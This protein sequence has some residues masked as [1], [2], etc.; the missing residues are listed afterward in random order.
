MRSSP[1]E[2]H[3]ERPLKMSEFTP[4]GR[5]SW[6]KAA[7][8]MGAAVLLGIVVVE[9]LDWWRHVNEPNARV[10]VD[11]TLLSS[12][13]NGT[14]EVVHARRGQRV[15]RGALLA[16]MDT[17]V[18]ELDV[19]T[20]AAEIAK[21]RARRSQIEAE[22]ANYQREMTD[23]IATAQAAVNLLR[24]EHATWKSRHT[25]AQRNVERNKKLAARRTI[26]KRQFDEARDRLL[27]VTSNLRSLE[28]EYQTSQKKLFELRNALKKETVY[29]SRIEAIDRA[30]DKIGVQLRQS[31]QR[32]ADMH[33]HAPIAGVI[34]EVYLSA[35]VYVEDGDRAFLLHDPDALWLEAR[36]DESDISLVAPGQAVSIEFDAYPFEYF[37][38]MVRTIGHATLGSMTSGSKQTADP[39]LAQRIPVLIDLPKMDKPVRPGMRASVNITVR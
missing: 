29:R 2:W 25:I 13:V 12:S 31:K 35:G 16:S 28:T 7:L 20:L 32:L 34:D 11:F 6:L 27:D 8:F 19:A 26:S 22:L 4:R 1:R 9:S 30:I 21:E 5:R 24:R 17:A 33:I 23:K 15:E 36:V 14:V 18:A 3:D 37:D 38:G 10:Q 39:R